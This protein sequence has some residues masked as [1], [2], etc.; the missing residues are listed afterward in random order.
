M[1]KETL[2]LVLF[3]LIYGYSEIY[4]QNYG[5]ELF[6]NGN[7]GTF[8]DG[9]TGI[10]TTVPLY[11]TV[12]AVAANASW[13][14]YIFQP[15]TQVFVNNGTTLQN[16]S[17]NPAVTIAP[18]LTSSQTGYT[19]GMNEPSYSTLYQFENGSG[20][21]SG[22]QIPMAPLNDY[23][24]I[25]T[26]TQGMYN[27]PTVSSASW[28]IVYDKYETNPAHPSNYFLIV[29]TGK[30]TAHIFYTQKIKMKRGNVYRMSADLCRLNITGSPP[31]IGFKF[32][33]ATG[34]DAADITTLGS[35]AATYSTG[36]MTQGAGT[37]GTYT[38]DYHATCSG[39]T[40]IGNPA[41]SVMIWVAFANVASGNGNN[42]AL[43]NLSFKEV[44]F[45]TIMSVSG[46]SAPFTVTLTPNYDTQAVAGGYTFA[47]LYGG[48]P[49]TTPGATVVNGTVT[50][51]YGNITASINATTH[52][53]TLTGV[54]DMRQVNG[55]YYT[56]TGSGGSATCTALSPPIDITPPGG[57]G[58]GTVTTPPKII[59]NPDRVQ[60]VPGSV[61][62]PYNI[63]T[64][65][66]ARLGSTTTGMDCNN[67]TINGV[68]VCSPTLLQVLNFT[69]TAAGHGIN[70]SSAGTFTPG[71]PVVLNDSVGNLLGV[72]NIDNAGDLT[73]TMS[74]TY[75]TPGQGGL[76]TF[77]FSYTAINTATGATAS[78]LVTIVMTVL[79]YIAEATCAGYPVRIVFTVPQFL[80]NDFYYT[81]TE[82]QSLGL[83][84]GNPGYPDGSGTGGVNVSP[85][86]SFPTAS[87]ADPS[88]VYVNDAVATRYYLVDFTYIQAGEST[89]ISE[90]GSLPFGAN[91]IREVHVA[92]TNNYHDGG[93]I[94]FEFIERI[95]GMHSY[96]LR[97]KEINANPSY[98]DPGYQGAA[99]PQ[100]PI[101]QKAVVNVC[102]ATAIW[103][104]QSSTQ[105]KDPNNWST[106]GIGTDFPVCCSDVFIPS[107]E[108]V[109]YADT[110][111][112]TPVIQTIANYP[113]LQ[114]GDA[115]RDI[116]FKM[117]AS[118]G[119]IQNLTYRAAYVE[120]TPPE[121]APSSPQTLQSIDNSSGKWTMI[122]VPLK[123]VYSAD[124]QPD[125]N[126]GANAFTD[127]KSYMSYFDLSYATNGITNPDGV[128]GTSLGSFSRPFAN[129]KEP[130]P[131]GFG[132]ASRPV[133][134]T[135]AA[136][137]PTGS[138]FV[139]TDSCKT[140][141]YTFYFPRYINFGDAKL[142]EI[143][144][145]TFGP[146]N[147]ATGLYDEAQYAYHY[148]DNGEWVTAQ[149][150]PDSRYY[151]FT[152]D[153]MRGVQ[154]IKNY[155][156]IPMPY[157]VYAQYPWASTFYLDHDT[158][159][160]VLTARGTT[161][162]AAGQW[163]TYLKSTTP[164][165]SW[166][167][168][169]GVDG[170]VY[171]YQHATVTYFPDSLGTSPVTGLSMLIRFR[172]ET[173]ASVLF[174][175]K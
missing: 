155:D 134:I 65:Y 43:D 127:I 19:F 174:M 32:L 172:D 105:W 93:K 128:S 84:S 48:T 159:A 133:V 147:M 82:A 107:P 35:T 20:T 140:Q 100:D 142:F 81:L 102:S 71:I 33:A 73:F 25:A 152:F 125:A 106:E 139:E 10:N 131:A 15:P 80:P 153:G 129:L 66:D 54:T 108:Q 144:N 34:N 56:F 118:V 146:S 96:Q 143:P 40:T 5:P 37:W 74:P 166:P 161:A 117:G 126:W 169:A 24:V 132:F 1:K 60:A 45:E 69:I 51:T 22:V 149:T 85:P 72:L 79:E 165:A 98:A 4:S 30:N 16:I 11:P 122:S 163:T 138:V 76:S 171:N 3:G 70:A 150:A 8:N 6:I 115:C 53:L 157:E 168:A 62:M 86:L 91:G 164:A 39:G 78:A 21:N 28:P 130:L 94:I 101:L 120:Y 158:V 47:W 49:P 7:F 88:M 58:G 31:S 26:S 99:F 175:R 63:I 83:V 59:A 95:P 36:N 112:A 12:V 87:T 135:D 57:G 61:N 167:P 42:I 123:Y 14:D 77:T 162:G 75:P 23:Y 55:F 50:T 173:V 18:P 29:H 44:L 27:A 90:T 64:G 136:G 151:P 97:K 170:A 145:T 52:V 113:I 89:Q 160:Y 137:N 116:I 119:K 68:Y 148:T 124:F 141:P 121:I 46:T 38:Y 2:L 103:V 13:A 17:I 104:G 154:A 156:T 92:R 109:I 67:D 111:G 9:V 110:V 114:T 41:D